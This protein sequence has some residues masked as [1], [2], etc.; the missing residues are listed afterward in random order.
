MS[1]DLPLVRGIDDIAM[2]H[3]TNVLHT[4][5]VPRPFIVAEIDDFVAAFE[6]KA[7]RSAV[8]V[9]A[10]AALSD[11]PSNVVASLTGVSAAPVSAS[12]ELAET[13]KRVDA[14]TSNA[15]VDGASHSSLASTTDALLDVVQQIDSVLPFASRRR[16]ME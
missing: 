4:C 10:V 6:P 14:V 7:T 2:Q 16:P 9:S 1:S 13:L 3:V 12:D 11:V 15:S 5:F 8:A